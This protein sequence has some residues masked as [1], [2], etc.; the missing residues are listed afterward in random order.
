MD[1]TL[2]G[3]T[4]PCQSGPENNV[5]EKVLHPSQIPRT[6]ALQLDAV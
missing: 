3:T 5:T 2:A 6:G 1:G 4:T